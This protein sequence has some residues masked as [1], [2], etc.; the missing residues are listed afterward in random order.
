[1]R[2]IAKSAK[3]HPAAKK[4][5]GWEEPAIY[6]LLNKWLSHYSWKNNR[7]VKTKLT[8]SAHSAVLQSSSPLTTDNQLTTNLS[9]TA[10]QP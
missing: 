6:D 3:I 10:L 9:F 7:Q 1:M 2:A 4:Y 8:S 5:C